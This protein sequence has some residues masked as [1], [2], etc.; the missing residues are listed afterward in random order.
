MCGI[1]GYIGFRPQDQ[2]EVIC[3]MTSTIQHRGPDHSE[4]FT[5][6]LACVGFNR[7]SILDLSEKGNQPFSAGETTIYC[8]GEIYNYLQLKKEHKLEDFCKSSSDVEILPYLYN[9]Y[10]LDFLKKINGMFGMVILDNKKN[11]V[12]LVTD[13]WGKKPIYY[14]QRKEGIF[15][16]SELKGLILG[17]GDLS[18]DREN[19]ALGLNLGYF[20][21]PLTPVK[22]V[23][24]LKPATLLTLKNNKNISIQQWYV[25][26]PDYSINNLNDRDLEELYYTHLDESVKMRL[27]ADVDVG[28][29]LSGGMDSTTVAESAARQYGKKIHAFVGLTEGRE[30]ST[31]YVNSLKFTEGKNFIIHK[32]YNDAN[33]YSNFLVPTC[34]SYDD[35][36]FESG[37]LNFMTITKAAQPHVKVLLDGVGGD[38]LFLGYHWHEGVFKRVNPF[39]R[40]LIPF[41]GRFFF[42]M[43]KNNSRMMLRSMIL[44]NME[45]WVYFTRNYISYD[46]MRLS[47]HYNPQKLFSILDEALPSY[48]KEFKNTTDLNCLA[49]L[50]LLGI[51]TLQHSFSDRTCMAYSIEN[52]SP[53]SD[54][55]L[56][57]KFLGVSE[58]R[59][60]AHGKKFLMKK[61]SSRLPE[62]IRG[63]EKEGFSSP[64]YLWFLKDK[65]LLNTIISYIK[66]KRYI[67]DDL[68]DH[69][70]LNQILS[71]WEKRELLSWP[72]GIQ[73]HM[74]ISVL[75]WHEI[76]FEKRYRNRPD[77]NIFEFCE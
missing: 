55:K 44:G 17:L 56:F 46:S 21:S 18:V 62:C 34:F 63:G 5:H 72:D 77:I 59:K 29:F 27:Q 58:K 47:K 65:K 71:K 16:C 11:E 68:V 60:L 23:L 39:L 8:N 43:F 53:L 74:M 33:S 14:I 10:G 41:G 66:N 67:L 25:L 76:F 32:C 36:P 4:I 51:R 3:S 6:N 9:L 42:D 7:L 28:V 75:I 30:N 50:E 54:Y 49:Y 52:R 40:N 19:L 1:A 69:A 13:Y 22:G 37:I 61:I 24:K 45:K 64:L 35:I 26:K 48:A 20:L 31:D 15:F 70:L 73:L 12:H 57:E 2:H 38:E